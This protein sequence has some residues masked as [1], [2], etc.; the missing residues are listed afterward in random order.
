[1]SADAT[2]EA[3]NVS[4]RVHKLITKQHYKTDIISTLQIKKE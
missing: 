2:E 1:M 3:F 4:E